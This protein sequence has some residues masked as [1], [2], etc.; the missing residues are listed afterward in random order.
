MT[1]PLIGPHQDFALWA[2]MI[3]LAAFGFWCE[4]YRWGRKYSGILLLMTLAMVLSN[5]RI[6]PTSAPAYDAAWDLLVPIAIALLL[7]EANLKRILSEAGPTLIAFIIGSAAVVAGVLIG[8]FALDLGLQEPELAG[9]YTGT[10][11]GGALN[12]AAVA[13][14][15]GLQDGSLL[16]AA[17]AADNVATNL[18]FLF[19]ILMPG[20]AW[21]AA[22]YPTQHM[23]TATDVEPGSQPVPHSVS[24]LGIPGLLTAFAIAFGLA[25]AGDEIS[26]RMNM[27]QY[28]I[29]VTTALTLLVATMF[30]KPLRKLSGPGEAGNVLMFIFLAGVG[31][32][33]DLWQLAAAGPTLF[34]FA[35]IIIGVHMLI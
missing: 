7:F 33:M 6:I 28:S 12:F 35:S 17:I 21:F 23:D 1:F 2:T 32:T 31:A 11:I 10:Y 22:R 24:A 19:L 30:A 4:R 15:S 25:A 14:A 13:K 9:V 27:P 8:A 26:A 3:G 20:I 29:I 18:H 16:G 34:V 5:L